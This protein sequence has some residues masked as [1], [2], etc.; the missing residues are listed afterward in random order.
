MIPAEKSTF[1]ERKG[2]FTLKIEAIEFR[3]SR[4]HQTSPNCVY[5]S[6][7]MALW[8]CLVFTLYLMEFSAQGAKEMEV[9]Q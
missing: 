6:F 7:R 8:I 3:K 2:K 9:G 1:K 4:L 5:K